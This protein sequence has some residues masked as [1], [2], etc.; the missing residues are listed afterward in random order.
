[1]FY[2]SETPQKEIAEFL[3]LPVSTVKNRLFSARRR[4]R[5]EM[6][7]VVAE[8]LCDLTPSIEDCVTE[9]IH[10]I[11]DRRRRASLAESAELETR[12]PRL[13]GEG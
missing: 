2:V 6:L 1:M 7:P 4:L 9:R 3:E 12:H 11:L 10:R 5:A 8:S 13:G